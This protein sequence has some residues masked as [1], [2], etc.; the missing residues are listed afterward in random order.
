MKTF[1][2]S[3]PKLNKWVEEKVIAYETYGGIIK[4]FGVE[5]KHYE[6]D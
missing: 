2:E 1:S 4:T 3:S 6:N 5:I